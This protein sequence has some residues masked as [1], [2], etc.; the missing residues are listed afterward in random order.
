[1]R[2]NDMIDMS[3]FDIFNSTE[4]ITKNG[5]EKRRNSRRSV[6]PSNFPIYIIYFVKYLEHMDTN[7][8]LL[9]F[10]LIVAFGLVTVIAV[11]I[12]LT[13]Q[14]AEAKGCSPCGS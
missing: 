10:A 6:F 2:Y 11:D 7:S 1:M 3:L 5:H 13:T 9:N 4:G 8:T 14:E 12:M